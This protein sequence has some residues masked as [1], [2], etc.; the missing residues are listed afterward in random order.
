MRNAV[1]VT[2]IILTGHVAVAQERSFGTSQAL[3]GRD[4]AKRLVEAPDDPDTVRLLMELRRY[5]E[6]LKVVRRIVDTR[7]ESMARAFEA[8]GVG[9]GV[10]EIGADAAHDYRD[11]LTSL[12][13]DA[14]RRASSLPREQ[15]AQLQRRLVT[16]K[17]EL[18]IGS[19][20]WRSLLT[21][22]VNEYAGTEAAL[23]AEVDLIDDANAAARMQALDAFVRTHP[24]TTAAAKALYLK[25]FSLGHNPIIH[26][27]RPGQDPTE[28]FFRVVD[29]ANE[30]R[31]GRYPP[32]EWVDKA[33]TL[34][35]DF[36]TYQPKYAES[37]AD[38][39]LSTL[40]RELPS[41][42]E[43]YEAESEQNSITYLIGRRMGDL[44][45]LKGD[46]V[47]GMDQV[48]DRLERTTHGTD[49]VRL[50]RAQLYLSPRDARTIDNV[51]SDLRAKADEL[52]TT[53]MDG[54]AQQYRRRALWMLAEL[55]F[56][57]GKFEAARPLYQKFADGYPD[58]HA[59]WV[60]ALRVGQCA[61]SL[62]VRDAGSTYRKAAERF[63][64]T[65]EAY[66]LGRVAAARVE[67]ALGNFSQAL[68]D[69]RATL[70]AWD[71]GDPDRYSLDGSRARPIDG[72]ARVDIVARRDALP[73]RIAELQR[74][75]AVAGGVLV[76]RGRW[77][78][79]QGRWADALAPLTAFLKEHRSS[80]LA[81]EARALARRA[82]LEQALD[83]VD[84]DK[85][86]ADVDGAIAALKVLAA[87][88]PDFVVCAAQIALATLALLEG[89]SGDPDA[90]MAGAMKTWQALDKPSRAERS[91]LEQDVLAIRNT[92][93][94]PKGDGIFASAQSRWNAF[95]W[96]KGAA[97]FVVV[98][99]DLHVK[100]PTGE[101]T[102]ILANDVFPD[103]PNIVFLDQERR[104]LLD[105]VMLKLGGTKRRAWTRVMDTP[106]QPAGASVDVLTLWKKSFAARPGHWGGWVFATYPILGEIEFIDAARTKAT[107]K[108]TVG[109]SGATVQMEKKD[110]VWIARELT[111]F[112]IT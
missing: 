93:F 92:V 79:G 23:L 63:K 25:G 51:R 54:P 36:F 109:Y 57:D 26:G 97:P 21:S 44:L 94:R 107:V 45:A 60:A 84:A 98:D 95:E 96:N 29:V 106:N 5:P 111:N 42:L 64:A 90:L 103:M 65:P 30:L 78:I 68:E 50:L 86:T 89:K 28:R 8:L 80:P 81:P 55:R 41:M 83:L 102:T 91:A 85:T 58:D 27:D 14:Q 13:A 34:I 37:N 101:E 3:R 52:L 62:G 49:A 56:G 33:Q 11:M 110:G 16:V 7:P 6:A 43:Q 2:L 39:M 24:G 31:S 87:E 12:V 32:S 104:A 82:R 19:N 88:P 61:E 10:R 74:S 72:M 40:E 69:Y 73:A 4:A 38:R 112:W 47:D 70:S 22:F 75:L 20:V 9:I 99:S 35:V 71:R 46:A 105:R 59:A 15:A 66:A 17:S 18:S 1:I 67:E 77:V 53:L 76:E 48:L 100:L 108:V